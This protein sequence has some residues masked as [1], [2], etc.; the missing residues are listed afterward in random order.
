MISH[1]KAKDHQ[2]CGTWEIPI[3]KHLKEFLEIFREVII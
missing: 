1:K 2:I 3:L